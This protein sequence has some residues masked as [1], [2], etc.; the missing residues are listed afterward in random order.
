MKLFES[1]IAKLKIS[2]SEYRKFVGKLLELMLEQDSGSEDATT[3]LLANPRKIVTAEIVAKETGILAGGEEI[4]FFFK[5]KGV[6]ILAR[7]KDGAKIRGGE[8]VIQLKGGAQ[9]IL[10]LE[11]TIL[12]L[13]QRMSGIATAANLLARKI[14]RRKFAATRKTPLGLLDKKAVVVGGGLPHRLNLSD[15]ILVKENHLAVDPNCWRKIL[16]SRKQ[17]SMFFEIEADNEKLALEIAEFFHKKKGLI[18]LLDNFTPTKLRKIIPKLRAINPKIIL[19]GSGGI[20]SKTAK[21][22]L[23]SGVDF[24]SIGELTHSARA[25]NFSLRIHSAKRAHP[26]YP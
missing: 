1:Q 23:K 15:Q 10:A 24:V 2:N 7:K 19:E 12:N 13:L 17:E 21:E 26:F 4:E 16:S 20:T 18:L 11:R 5:K 25:M 3:T 22:F 6:E 9:K 14:G 8:T